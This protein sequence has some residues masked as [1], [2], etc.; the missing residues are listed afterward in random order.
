L[1]AFIAGALSLAEAAQGVQDLLAVHF[2]ALVP[3]AGDAAQFL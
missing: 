2:D 1:F 3:E